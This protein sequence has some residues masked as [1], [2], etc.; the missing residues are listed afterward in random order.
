M[1]NAC[2]KPPADLLHDGGISCRRPWKAIVL[3]RCCWLHCAGCS[4]ITRSHSQL[5]GTLWHEQY[6][7]SNANA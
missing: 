6:E 3:M 7:A 2:Y 5:L 4:Y 1:L